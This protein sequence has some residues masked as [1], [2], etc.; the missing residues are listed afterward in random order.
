VRDEDNDT[1]REIIDDKRLCKGTHEYDWDGEDDDD[2]KVRQDDYEFYI[3]AENDE[4]TDTAR[5]DVT[6]DYNGHHVDD[7]DQCAG[8]DDVSED[9]PYCEAIEYV[10]DRGIF[11]GYPDGNFRPHQAINRAETTKVILVGFDYPLHSPDGTNAGFWDVVKE[12]W[13]M[14]YLRTAVDMNIIQ[15]YPDKSFQPART[16]NRVELLKIFLESAQVSLPY[17]STAPYSDTPIQ[18]D[19]AWYMDYVCYSKTYDLVDPDY[20]YRFNPAKPMTR[21]DVALLFYN[22]ANRGSGSVGSFSG[23]SDGD[24]EIRSL[25][26]SDYTVDPGDN[27]KIEYYLEAAADVTIEI[28]DDDND[29]IRTLIDDKWRSKGSHS[30]TWDGEDDDDDELDDG[31]YTVRIE[32]DNDDGYDKDEV[33]FEVDEDSGSSDIRISNLDLDDDIFDP[34][35]EDLRITFRINKDAF[36]TVKVYDDDNDKVATIWDE[37]NRDDGTYTIVWNGEDNNGHQLSDGDYTIKVIAVD[38]DDDDEK[39]EDEVDFEIDS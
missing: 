39:D 26:L 17:C 11:D 38:E 5:E 20:N 1:V 13:Y 32:A 25:K 27:I 8:Y 15:G 4:G 7:E 6:V 12:A 33:D 3:R 16:V 35:R 23:S 37:R 21:G 18:A 2:D 31:E 19:T 14:T 22:F 28:L 29:V 9:D 36:V 10:S 34:D 30:I 24:P